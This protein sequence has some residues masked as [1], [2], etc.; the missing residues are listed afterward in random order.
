VGFENGKLVK[1]ILRATR[2]ADQQVNTFHYDLIGGWDPLLSNGNNPQALADTFRDDVRPGWAAWYGSDWSIQPVQVVDEI[3]PQNPG[4]PRSSWT[5]GSAIAGTSSGSGDQLPPNLAIV[6]KLTTA[7]IGRRHTG[8]TWISGSRQESEQSYG[9]WVSGIVAGAETFM[10]TIP[11]EPDIQEGTGIG[12]DSAHWCVYSRT[13][14]AAD[15]D[16]YA[17]AVTGFAVRDLVHTLRSRA[18]YS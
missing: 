12:D 9:Q 7:L 13:A 3:D 8:R 1:V 18:L 14:R 4:D 2:G 11:M 16:P 17:S 6:V 15:Q 5:S 10:G